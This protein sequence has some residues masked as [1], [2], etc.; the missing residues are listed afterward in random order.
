MGITQD[1]PRSGRPQILSR[2]ARKLV[3]RAIRKNPKISYI[4]LAEVAQ[5]HPPNST[6]SKPP[7]RSTLY[8]VIKKTGLVHARCKKRPKLTPQRARARLLFAR[9]YRGYPW[10]RRIL[11]FSDECSIQKGSGNTTE[12]CF[13]YDN[14][15]WNQ[16]MLTELSTAR[17]P[18]QMV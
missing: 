11:K 18:A 7:S 4:E 15:K 10:H 2:Y 16:R 1:K 8:R 9:E 3:Y 13:R 17:K 6:P 14:E 12:W 5:V